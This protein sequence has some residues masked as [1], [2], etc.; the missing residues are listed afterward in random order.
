V[1][2]ARSE[3]QA[4]GQET[5]GE[6]T[7][8]RCL[9][10]RSFG[11]SAA[12]A[13]A[14]YVALLMLAS[15]DRRVRPA[16]G[17]RVRNA[18]ACGMIGLVIDRM[19][20]DE[21]EQLARL[22]HRYAET[23]LDQFD[24][25]RLDTEIGPVYVSMSMELPPDWSDRAFDPVPRPGTRWQTGRSAHVDD[26]QQVASGEDAQRVI[27]QMRADLSG[28]GSRESENPTL[29]RFLEALEA[30]LDGLPGRL[31]R[32]GGGA[33]AQPDWALLAQI[34]VAATGYE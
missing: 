13:I 7:R 19:S 3:S 33:T 32:Q 30:V 6:F 25:W 34:L 12:F 14:S 2:A 29:G 15:A 28:S 17:N 5:H 27:A 11:Y 4:Y 22:L 20:A 9:Q 23:E 1:T 24:D 16:M 21:V 18:A 10:W 26:A 31:A 8:V